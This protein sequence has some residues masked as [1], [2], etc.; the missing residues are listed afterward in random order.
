DVLAQQLL[1]VLRPHATRADDRDVRDIAGRAV[2]APAEHVAGNDHRAERELAGVAYEFAAGHFAAWHTRGSPL[3]RGRSAYSSPAKVAMQGV[4]AAGPLYRAP[5]PGG[6]VSSKTARSA[7][8]ASAM[9]GAASAP[10]ATSRR[11]TAAGAT[12]AS[13]QWTA[14]WTHQP[15]GVPP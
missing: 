4:A 11:A 13:R 6:P 8:G 15:S 9:K 2:T 7:S 3:S 14:P 12:A 1:R 10:A 5:C